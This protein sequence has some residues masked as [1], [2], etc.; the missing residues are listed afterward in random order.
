MAPTRHE[1][2]ISTVVE[3]IKSGRVDQH[4]GELMDAIAER[5][6]ERKDVVRRLVREVFGDD[7][8]IGP[9]ENPFFKKVR[10]RSER[11]GG[12][13]PGE[14]LPGESPHVQSVDPFGDESVANNDDISNSPTFGARPM[15]D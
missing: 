7:Y 6:E 8:D 4:I 1:T 11:E 10:E 14:I 5:N 15:F 3:L 2:Q 13:A 9:K 12:R